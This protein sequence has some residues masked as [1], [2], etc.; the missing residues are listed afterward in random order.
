MQH[1][2]STLST[3]LRACF[4]LK[5]LILL[6]LLLS[7]SFLA[8]CDGESKTVPL[9]QVVIE[10]ET[11]HI[12]MEMP[13]QFVAVGIDQDGNRISELAFT[14]SVE[15]GGGTIDANGLFTAGISPGS[16]NAT[17][18]AEANYGDITHSATASVTVE[19]DRITFTS[20]LN[21]DQY[22]IYIMDADGT[23]VERLTT[24]PVVENTCS[25]SPDGRRVIYDSLSINDGILVMNDDGSWTVRL[26]ANEQ[27]VA[28]VYPAWSPDGS[29]IVFVTITNL[30]QANESWDIFVTD[31]DG[32]N[33]TQLTNTSLGDTVWVP[34]WSPDGTKIVYDF[35]PKG[36]AGDIYLMNADGSNPQCLTTDE[37]ND[38]CPSFSPNGTQILFGSDR[39]GDTEIYVM[40]ADGTDVRQLTSNKA[41]DWEP[42]WS[43]D[44][45]RI[46]F[47][48]D[49]DGDWEVYVMN[50]DGSGVLQLTD[51][52]AED[53][54]ASW[55]PRKMGLEVAEA[56][57]AIGDAGILE[58]MTV[59]EVT[60][61][62]RNA[63]V[64]IQTDLG[65]GSGFIVDPSGL[66]L[67]AN[68]VITDAEEITVYLDDGTSY[69][70]TVKGRDLIHDLAVIM[71]EAA[72]LPYLELGDLSQVELGQQVVVLGYPLDEE[73]ITITGGFVSAIKFDSGRNIDWVQT[74]SA[75]NPG[76]SGAPLLNLQGQAIGVVTTKL[77]GFAIEGVGFAISAKTVNMHLPRLEAG[78]TIMTLK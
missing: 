27:T 60:T 18:K 44:G 17:V 22:D 29:K 11:V 70:A 52:S 35:T 64:R 76:N 63:V 21:D 30:D 20:D 74:D 24:S 47:E 57:I 51:N 45:N 78:Q 16:Y 69:T 37:A 55:A 42:S 40:N 41:E 26:I 5:P 25:W 59:E 2:E 1:S 73:E 61:Q 49:K 66:V 15:K 65:S 32:G 31:V 58:T 4:H 68:H 7:A 50:A 33:M 8:A 3:I 54:E 23:N 46:V 6:W 77:V 72:E 19:P 75:I 14:W 39:D 43:P 48:S 56:S 71:I 12:G 13:Q 67:T 53:G 36:Q 28:H 10:P 62:A 34:A 9:E 38:S